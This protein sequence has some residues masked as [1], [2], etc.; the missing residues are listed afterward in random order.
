M[1][2]KILIVDDEAAIRDLL[3]MT[4]QAEGFD[5]TTAADVGSALSQIADEPPDLLLLDWMLPDISGIELARRLNRDPDHAELPIIMLTARGEEDSKIYGLDSGVDDYITKPFSRRELISRIKALLR[6]TKPHQMDQPLICG[7]LELNP[8][9]HRVNARGETLKLGPT[10]YRLLEFFMSHPERVYS[11]EQL[12]NRVWG[13]NVYVEDRTVDVHV[14]RLRKALK[15]ARL[16]AMI[17]TVR[18][19]GYRFAL[20]ASDGDAKSS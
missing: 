8:V 14:L 1:T 4:L 18:G 9:S 20:P 7:E 2:T 15:P 3:V 19:S 13:G 16:D 11:R 17:E 6:R 10:E 12:L 5:T